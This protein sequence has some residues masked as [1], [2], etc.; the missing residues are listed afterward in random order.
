MASVC[1]ASRESDSSSK[2]EIQDSGT[3]ET[4]QPPTS[5]A[6]DTDHAAD[7]RH[8]TPNVDDEEGFD[9]A[10][11]LP[12]YDWGELEQRFGEA[13]AKCDAEFASHEEEWAGLVQV[14]T[15]PFSNLAT[16]YR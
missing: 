14:T 1:P 9:P 3:K 6:G 10:D 15:P 13:M 4:E 2:T 8:Q 11:D 16:G 5:Q 12:G 7:R